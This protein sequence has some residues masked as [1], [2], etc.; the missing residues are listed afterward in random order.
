M[1]STASKS[2]KQWHPEQEKI[3][4]RWGE[5]SAC[6]RFLH[7][8]SYQKF[9]R[10]VM[11]YTLPIIIIST[12]TGTANFA[13]ESFPDSWKEY[14]PLF[15]GAFNLFGGILSTV[16]QFLKVNE[17]MESHRVSSIHYGKLSRTIR[18]ELSLPLSER[19][20]NGVD[21]I[22][23]CKIEYDRLIEQSPPITGDIMS[24]FEEK[25]PDK[26]DDL[27][28]EFSRPEILSIHPINTYENFYKTDAEIQSDLEEIKIHQ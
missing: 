8:K 18:L 20:Y 3:L 1:E 13:H 12:I 17:L 21:M 7:Y 5:N 11:R 14:V 27:I 25:Y 4:K 9:R 2:P 28:K 6:Y 16:Q 24:V 22:E 15:I 23:F 10:S 19:S 26:N